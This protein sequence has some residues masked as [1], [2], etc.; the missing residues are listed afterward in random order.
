MFI[1]KII[2]L[3]NKRD[4]FQLQI[5]LTEGMLRSWIAALIQG[6]DDY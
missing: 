5:D 3:L 2:G 6:K 1:H 4:I